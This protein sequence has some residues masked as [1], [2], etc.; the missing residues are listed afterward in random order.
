MWR[1]DRYW[2]SEGQG[3]IWIHQVS[4]PIHNH[5]IR[6]GDCLNSLTTV[7]ED[8]NP[9]TDHILLALTTSVPSSHSFWMAVKTDAKTRSIFSGHMLRLS[10]NHSPFPN[11]R[12]VRLNGNGSPRRGCRCATIAT[13]DSCLG[14]I[15]FNDAIRGAS[16]IRPLPMQ[17]I[18]ILITV[19][20]I[21]TGAWERRQS[22]V[23]NKKDSWL[24]LATLTSTWCFLKSL[25]PCR[26]RMCQCRVI[27]RR[28]VLLV[29]IQPQVGVV[30]L[31]YSAQEL[32]H[33]YLSHNTH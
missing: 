18:L 23:S 4:I 1:F 24:V 13:V 33:S 7:I 20:V 30:K 25:V 15:S 17:Y 9:C 3:Y 31:L 6:K 28:Q 26:L 22:H 2:Q 8:S 32:T 5:N 19:V 12:D 11:Q 27:A 16:R 14:L 21:F 10:P 29:S